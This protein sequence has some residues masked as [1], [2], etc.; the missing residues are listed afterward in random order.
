[1]IIVIFLFLFL[2]LLLLLLCFKLST[3]V[4]SLPEAV[5]AYSKKGQASNSVISLRYISRYYHFTNS[6]FRIKTLDIFKQ[7]I[8]R[9][10]KFKCFFLKFKF[11]FEI[12]VGE[13]T[14]KSPYHRRSRF[15]E[16]MCASERAREVAPRV[17]VRARA[18]FVDVSNARGPKGTAVL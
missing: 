13:I 4:S 18:T 16:R 10:V 3:P 17:R 8:A 7:Y 14:V 6:N 12:T 9:G 1:M 2:F 15:D 11:S 5:E